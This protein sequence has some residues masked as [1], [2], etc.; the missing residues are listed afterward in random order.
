MVVLEFFFNDSCH[1]GAQVQILD[2]CSHQ[3][4]GGS[5]GLVFAVSVVD[6]D[7]VQVAFDLI[8]PA[9]IGCALEV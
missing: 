4:H 6:Q 8:Y 3:A 5:G 7:F 2:I 9:E 1:L